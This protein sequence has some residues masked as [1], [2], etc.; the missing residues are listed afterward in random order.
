MK[1]N[2]CFSR[3]L[4]EKKKTFFHLIFKKINFHSIIKFGFFLKITKLLNIIKKI[5][6]FSIWSFSNIFYQLNLNTIV[7]SNL[8]RLYLSILY[9]LNNILDGV[10][11]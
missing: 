5:L 3:F 2:I 11:D 10:C 8:L 1:K 4:K 9:R 7:S 6:M